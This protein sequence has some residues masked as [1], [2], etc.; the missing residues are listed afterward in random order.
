[1]IEF[2]V[3][4][5][6]C[7]DCGEIRQV[8]VA[9]AEGQKRY[10]R[11]FERLVIDLSR[12]TTPM[13]VARYLDISW[14]AAS[15]IQK[16]HLKRKYGQPKLKPLK[17]IAIDEIYLGKKHQ[18]ITL[19]LDLISG[20]VVFVG[21]GKG[22]A[23]LRPFWRRLKHS[24]AE[25]VAVATDFS[26]AYTAAARKC[27]PTATHVFDRFH[28]VKLLNEKLS[29]LRRDLHREATDNLGKQALKGIRWLLLM[30]RDNLND[31]RNDRERLD[32]ALRFNQ[33]LATAY[34]LKEELRQ[35]WLQRNL[36]TATKFLESW[37]RRATASGIKVLITFAKTLQIH[38]HGLLAWYNHPISTGPLEGTN[39]K[40][41]LMQRRAYGYRNLEFLMLKIYGAHETRHR[42]VG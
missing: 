25:I 39:N 30:N 22:E 34:Y 13:D 17:I 41:K 37:C 16:K 38:R 18:S 15:E 24:R 1:M 32:E 4:R 9:F 5:L 14:D 6:R 33:P 28:V 31:E 10:T 11:C 7:Q 8:K 36:A 20:A 2:A 27:I 40:I 35:F 26:Q 23:S 19:V 42:L 12:Y 29:Q 21:Q 3:P